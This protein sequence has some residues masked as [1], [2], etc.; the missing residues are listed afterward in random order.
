MLRFGAQQAILAFLVVLEVLH[1]TT[2]AQHLVSQL[3]Y[4][5]VTTIQNNVLVVDV[6]AIDTGKDSDDLIKCC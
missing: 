4:L 3:G 2:L 6:Q 5:D 1:H